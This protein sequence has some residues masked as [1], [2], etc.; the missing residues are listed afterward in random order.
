[1]PGFNVLGAG[2]TGP[3]N[4]IEIRRKHR[5]QFSVIGRGS[6][7]F[8]PEELLVLQTA[9]RPSFKFDEPDMHHNQEVA[10]F[11]GKQTWDPVKLVWYDVQQDPDVSAGI[12]KWIETVVAMNAINVAHPAK[13]KKTASLDMLDGFGEPTET[14]TMYGTWPKEC[15][16]QE[17]DY[18]STD[19]MTIEATMRFDRAVRSCISSKSQQAT[20]PTC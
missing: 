20:S 7:Y 12:Y 9:S 10:Y 1:M 19:L 3:S 5:W 17:L 6:G 13:Y 18:V 11:A 8:R 2:G 15:N 14:W 4:V 16:W